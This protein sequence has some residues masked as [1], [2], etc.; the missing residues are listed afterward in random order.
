MIIPLVRS[1]SESSMRLILC[2][3]SCLCRRGV[4]VVAS[5]RPIRI[6]S[7][8]CRSSIVFGEELFDFPVIYPGADR[9]LEIFPRDRIPVL[10]ANISKSQ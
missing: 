6:V 10:V 4:H 2:R 9:E 5:A 7:V 1:K 8:D 3:V